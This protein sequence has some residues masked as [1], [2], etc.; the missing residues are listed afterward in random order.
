[1]DSLESDG[2]LDDMTIKVISG[3]AARLNFKSCRD[4][5]HIALATMR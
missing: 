3:V 1:M 2:A 4:I 5:Q